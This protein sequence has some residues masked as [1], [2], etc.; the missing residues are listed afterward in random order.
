MNNGFCKL[1]QNWD[2]NENICVNWLIWRLMNGSSPRFNN[3][4]S[5][6]ITS[7]DPTYL[8]N[9]NVLTHS[10]LARTEE[11]NSRSHTLALQLSLFPVVVDYKWCEQYKHNK[12]TFW[13]IFRIWNRTNLSVLWIQREWWHSFWWRI[14]GGWNLMHEGKGSRKTVCWE[15]NIIYCRTITDCENEE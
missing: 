9:Y 15:K 6:I 1:L 3:Q 2:L 14:S 8:S 10:Y 5:S 12:K 13:I 11:V 4:L 7:S